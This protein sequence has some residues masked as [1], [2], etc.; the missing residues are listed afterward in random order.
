MVADSAHNS[1]NSFL[2]QTCRWFSE[3]SKAHFITFF[4][5]IFS[6]L[7]DYSS[8]NLQSSVTA[9]TTVVLLSLYTWETTRVTRVLTF[10]LLI[11]PVFLHIRGISSKAVDWTL[12]VRRAIPLSLVGWGHAPRPPKISGF[13]WSCYTERVESTNVL[14]PLLSSCS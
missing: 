12:R 14:F 2:L 13:R 4:A 7:V 11:L 9:V 10:P 3:P 5:R 8:F 1:V 6:I